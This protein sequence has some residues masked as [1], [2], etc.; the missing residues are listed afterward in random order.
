MDADIHDGLGNLYWDAVPSFS[1]HVYRSPG[2][3]LRPSGHHRTSHGIVT[4][5][6]DVETRMLMEQYKHYPFS[7]PFFQAIIRTLVWDECYSSGFGRQ[8][9]DFSRHLKSTRHHCSRAIAGDGIYDR[10]LAA[11]AARQ[12]RLPTTAYDGSNTPS[13]ER[14]VARCIG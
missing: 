4:N 3:A 10:K 6:T 8:H 5:C 1:S 7:I 14:G 9:D 12:F 2:Q 11:Q 13:M